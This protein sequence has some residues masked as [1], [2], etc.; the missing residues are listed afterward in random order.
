MT[1]GQILYKDAYIRGKMLDHSSW[2]K[3]LPRNITPSDI[4]AVIDNN[5]KIL[6]IELSSKTSRWEELAYG[7]RLLYQNM[8]K[9]GNGKIFAALAHHNAPGDRAIDTAKDIVAFTVM[10][11]L[12]G[13]LGYCHKDGSKWQT[14]VLDFC[15]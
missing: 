4:D 12:N 7:Q 8:V 5:G 1:R 2:S 10:A 6:L 11:C 9:A 3:I 13:K 14:V 15:K